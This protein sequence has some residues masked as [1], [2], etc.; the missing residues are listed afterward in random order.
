MMSV[1]VLIAACSQDV[2][3]EQ[4]QEPNASLRLAAVSRA[5]LGEPEYGDIRFYLTNGTMATEGLFKYAGVSGWTTQLKLK[6]GARTYNLYGYMPDNAESVSLSGWNDNGAVLHIEQIAPIA[7]QDYYIVTGVRRADNLNDETPANRGVFS[8]DYN[9]QRDNYIYLLLDHVY[10]HV[11]FCMKVGEDY[12]ALRTIKIKNMKLK[13]P[14]ISLYDVDITLTKGVGISNMASSVS[15]T[16]ACEL[17]IKDKQN[18]EEITLTTTSQTVC[19]SYVI[20]A[21]TLLANLSLVIEYDIYDKQGHKIGER[22]ATNA[23][24]SPL[25]DVRRGEELKLQITID[26]SY[27]Y[28]LSLDDPP[29]VVIRES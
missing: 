1:F 19:S 9:S 21:T 8:F 23:L 25:K 4:T 17:T 29:I 27:L 13:V 12:D 3:E 24:A 28:D 14:D 15:G 18:T 20:P 2:A 5:I 10:S 7:E 16:E 22:E 11:V 6:S 26:P